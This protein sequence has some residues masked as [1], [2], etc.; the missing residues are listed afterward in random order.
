MDPPGGGMRTRA[1]PGPGRFVVFALVCLLWLSVLVFYPDATIAGAAGR[2]WF[3]NWGMQSLVSLACRVHPFRFRILEDTANG[4]EPLAQLP[5]L[6]WFGKLAHRLHPFIVQP[7]SL[8]ALHDTMISAEAT[9]LVTSV[10]VA[11]LTAVSALR[12][13]LEVALF[14]GVWNLLFNLYPVALQRH[15]LNRLR[16]VRNRRDRRGQAAAVDGGHECCS[17]Q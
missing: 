12:G 9:H 7:K 2:A 16:G 5:G 15:N 17:S 10:L 11:I 6:V 4:H 14:L 8:S 13:E 3:A 1:G